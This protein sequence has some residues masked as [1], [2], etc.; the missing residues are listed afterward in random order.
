MSRFLSPMAFALGTLILSAELDACRA[1][2]PD[3]DMKRDWLNLQQ[4]A[5]EVREL[6]ECGIV[7]LVKDATAQQVQLLDRIGASYDQKS[8]ALTNAIEGFIIKYST[9][10]GSTAPRRPGESI[11]SFRYRVWS[12]SL[13]VGESKHRNRNQLTTVM[14]DAMASSRQ[15]R[16]KT[17]TGRFITVPSLTRGKT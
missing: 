15:P 17:E 3:E 12:V 8:E 1:Q 6:E 2:T 5:T 9:V 11:A 4:L 13:R 14:C 7:V 16:A 10:Q